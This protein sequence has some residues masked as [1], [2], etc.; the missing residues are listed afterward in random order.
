MGEHK[1]YNLYY[2]EFGQPE[3]LDDE[4]KTLLKDLMKKIKPSNVSR[5]MI[6]ILFPKRD[7]YNDL[8]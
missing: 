6:N 7:E 8:I 4:D 3:K 5:R 2:I 1:V